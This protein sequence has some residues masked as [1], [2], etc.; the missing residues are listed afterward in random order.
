MNRNFIRTEDQKFERNQLIEYNR[1]KRA[2]TNATVFIL[3]D[4]SNYLI[5][6]FVFRF[7]QLI[8]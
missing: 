1:Q 6:A 2:E 7:N 4:F 8:F 5:L 3:I